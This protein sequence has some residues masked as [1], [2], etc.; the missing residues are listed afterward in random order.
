MENNCVISA[1]TSLFPHL[2]WS[3]VPNGDQTIIN[4]CVILVVS[5]FLVNT[6]LIDFFVQIFCENG[7]RCR[8]FDHS[9]INFM[10]FHS[11]MI[12]FMVML[13]LCVAFFRVTEYKL[14]SEWPKMNLF[15]IQFENFV[16]AYWPKVLFP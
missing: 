12:K 14:V 8:Q 11:W 5:S 2:G 9:N 7:K 16:R 4:L 15:S 10:Q 3:T 1:R 13:C 6:S